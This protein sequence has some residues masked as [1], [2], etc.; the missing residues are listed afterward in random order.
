[1]YDSQKDLHLDFYITKICNETNYGFMNINGIKSFYFKKKDCNVGLFFSSCYIFC[2]KNSSEV[3]KLRTVDNQMT[4]A[5]P[6]SYY[7]TF[8]HRECLLGSY[9]KV[10]RPFRLSYSKGFEELKSILVSEIDSGRIIY[11]DVH[12]LL[13]LEKSAIETDLG[14][15]P[16]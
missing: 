13:D 6:K 14:I 7:H 15:I 1:M 8:D 12:N 3:I 4:N 16:Q 9:V 5:F 11:I 10:R 2:N